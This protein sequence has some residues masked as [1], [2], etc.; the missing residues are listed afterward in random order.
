MNKIEFIKTI[1][2]IWG[3]RRVWIYTS[4]ARTKARFAR[5]TIGG[6]WLGI[7]NLLSIAA[8]AS[9][10]GVVLNV[11]NF[12]FYVIYLGCGLVCWNS[13]S[14]AITS[15]PNLF[16]L[17][18][19]QILNTNT[20]YIFY[21][22]EEW[23][24]NLQGFLQSFILVL[25]SLSFFKANLFL[26]LLTVGIL[27]L[28]NFFIFLYWFPV[29]VAVISLR[30]KDFYQLVPIVIQLV[31]LLSPFLYEKETLGSLSWTAT[32]NP[33]YQIVASLRDS[34]IIGEIPIEKFLII[35]F[36]NLLG[37]FFSILLLQ[38]S[39]KIIPFLL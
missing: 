6:F 39:K 8:L 2:Y 24:F 10:Y 11:D 23:S 36:L 14:S 9:V 7:S 33:I 37:T 16:I 4:L 12:N 15:A 27:P 26:N 17:N 25:V 35:F 31:F 3:T 13:I 34:I 38:K 20:N 28:I 1:K 22:L 5:T 29:F 32:F 21:T 19:N 30:Y 18:T